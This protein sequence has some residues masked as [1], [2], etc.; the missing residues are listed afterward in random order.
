M[1]GNQPQ[2]NQNEDEEE[3]VLLD[4]DDVCVEADIPANAPYV[5]SDMDTMNPVLLIGDHLKLIGEYQETIGTC[6]VFSENDDTPTTTMCP[7]TRPSETNSSKD[8]GI[9]DAKEAPSKQVKPIASVHKILKFKLVTED[10]NEVAAGV[11][12]TIS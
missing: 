8:K 11:T 1:E 6:Y 7:E 9:V 10:Q 3:Y 2:V 4:L 5:L 12:T